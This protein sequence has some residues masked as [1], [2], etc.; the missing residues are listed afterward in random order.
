MCPI[1]Y[2]SQQLTV[3]AKTE[4]AVASNVIRE[5]LLWTRRK[6][7]KPDLARSKIL[8]AVCK[9]GAAAV[10]EPRAITP[11]LGDRNF[12]LG[13]VYTKVTDRLFGWPFC[14]KEVAVTIC[15]LATKTV[16]MEYV[17]QQNAVRT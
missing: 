1:L 17:I 4:I 3:F 6:R 14:Q 8:F 7:L 11:S 10:F 12:L 5:A 9:Q 2:S 13:S 15:R 16:L